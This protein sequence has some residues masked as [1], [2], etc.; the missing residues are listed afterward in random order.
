[1][2]RVTILDFPD[3]HQEP[4]ALVTSAFDGFHPLAQQLCAH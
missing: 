4:E 1:V 3:H 2:A